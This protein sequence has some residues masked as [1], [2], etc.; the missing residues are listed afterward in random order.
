MTATQ[1]VVA[2]TVLM[3]LSMIVLIVDRAVDERQ[4]KARKQQV[5]QATRELVAFAHGGSFEKNLPVSVYLTAASRLADIIKGAAYQRMISLLDRQGWLYTYTHKAFVMSNRRRYAAIKMLE[6]FNCPLTIL[7][8]QRV[9]ANDR[10]PEYR[11]M[12]ALALLRFGGLP[13]IDSTIKFLD[14]TNGPIGIT[15]LAVLRELARQDGPY[16]EA[17]SRE[18]PR[19]F[20]IAVI[21]CLGASNEHAIFEKLS[22]WAFSS[23]AEIAE[24]IATSLEWSTNSTANEILLDLLEHHEPRVRY[25]ALVSLWYRGHEFGEKHR[26]MLTA[27][28]DPY[29]GSVADF[30]WP[31]P[32]TIEI[33]QEPMLA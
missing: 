30:A 28:A 8:L 24:A 29:V 3:L 32:R 26:R 2:S 16:L 6:S 23:D 20:R 27:T 15:E 4:D 5:A 1:I 33:E 13:S 18:H 19:A 12:A 25:R 22:R 11:K 10:L 21:S 17:I 7:T 9:M 14:L 31:R